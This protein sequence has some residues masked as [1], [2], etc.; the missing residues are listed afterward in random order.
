MNFDC[1]KTENCF[2]DSQTYEYLLPVIAEKFLECLD[3]TWEK[4]CNQKLRRP[5]FIAERDGTRIKGILAGNV[6]RVSF[7]N[8]SWEILK[9]NFEEWM[10][11]T[12]E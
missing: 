10:R 11:T 4:R 1:K 5:V 7:L 3:E 8:D 12:H 9:N 6:I 2:V